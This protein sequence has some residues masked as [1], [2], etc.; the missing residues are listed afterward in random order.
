[1]GPSAL[2]FRQLLQKKNAV[3]LSFVLFLVQSEVLKALAF[4][5][6]PQVGVC[7][8]T[9]WAKEVRAHLCCRSTANPGLISR[10]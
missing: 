10:P 1:M 2:S 4:A 7:I 5:L 6:G 8:V 3:P 9:W